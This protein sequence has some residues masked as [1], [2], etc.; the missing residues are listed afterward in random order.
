MS[1]NAIL[2][3]MNDTETEL[4]VG[5]FAVLLALANFCNKTTGQCNPCLDS[6]AKHA[7]L[8]LTA[9]KKY[10][11][12]LKDNGIIHWITKHKGTKDAHNEYNLKAY[13]GLGQPKLRAHQSRSEAEVKP[14]PGRMGVFSRGSRNQGFKPCQP[15]EPC[16]T[17]STSTEADV[18]ASGIG[19]HIKRILQEWNQLPQVK[20]FQFAWVKGAVLS[21]LEEFVSSEN[22]EQDWEQIL[23]EY[24]SSEFLQRGGD[25]AKLNTIPWLFA[26]GNKEKVLSAYFRTG[27]RQSQQFYLDTANY[28]EAGKLTEEAKGAVT[29]KSIAAGFAVVDM[30]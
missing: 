12:S 20:P 8:G 25:S 2:A 30:E 7:R 28:D 1:V 10:L 4:S 27:T 13:C 24:K 22:W 17:S 5:E 9:T 11:R 23:Q 6:I 15:E 3:V 21:A 19:A 16:L 14:H 26:E 18:A 29:Q